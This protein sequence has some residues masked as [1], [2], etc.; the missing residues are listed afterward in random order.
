VANLL[1]GRYEVC[2]TRLGG[3]GYIGVCHGVK[4]QGATQRNFALRQGGALSGVVR[5]PSGHGIG[6][7]AVIAEGQGGTYQSGV[8][9]TRRDGSFTVSALGTGNYRVCFD[10]STR[11]AGT[12]SFA[13]SCRRQN[14]V[15]TPG[16]NRIG[17][18]SALTPGGA[19]TGVVHAADGT[20]ISDT[21]V[22]FELVRN[23][24]LVAFGTAES[25]G[26]GR[27]AV[28]GLAPGNY[29]VCAAP[30]NGGQTEPE[31]CASSL[32]VV[33][34]GHTTRHA[35]V[36]MAQHPSVL[37]HVTDA[38]GHALSGVDVGLL[39]RCTRSQ[40]G[41]LPV[42]GARAERVVDTAMTDAAGNAHFLQVPAG[43]YGVCALA[44]YGAAASVPAPTGYADKC[45]DRF[46][47]HATLTSPGSSTL[48][49]DPGGTVSGTIVDGAGHPIRNAVVHIGGAS[50]EGAASN[51]L[52]FPPSP[53]ADL[54]TD[55]RGR[56]SVHSVRPGQRSVCATAKGY[57]RGC[58]AGKV[59]VAAA[60]VTSAGPLTLTARAFAAHSVPAGEPQTS[61]PYCA[62]RQILRRLAYGT[63]GAL[64]ARYPVSGRRWQP[65]L[66]AELG[67]RS[68]C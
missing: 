14:V 28:S 65:R 66:F 49:L 35:V 20:P 13:P 10:S 45:T 32:V 34:A 17:A 29:R 6:G 60:T 36:T 51:V 58:L 54:R 23:G 48:Q 25:D 27:F 9:I 5:G 3:L 61:A 12:T 68:G 52:S 15:V 44:Y 4:V 7:V 33:T 11:G 46:P 39:G 57:Q 63:F 24:R 21:Y 47:V 1:A 26:H 42:F 59:T 62:E 64:L 53:F 2:A 37:V 40:C 50:T 43:Y 31:Q 55:S 22:A 19:V 8:A 18:D 67:H 38:S 16:L 30:G 56:Y 41:V